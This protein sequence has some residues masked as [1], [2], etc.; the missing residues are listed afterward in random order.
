MPRTVGGHSI[1]PIRRARRSL[2]M[3]AAICLLPLTQTTADDE[4]LVLSPPAV[5]D[6]VKENFLA[7]RAGILPE[8]QVIELDPAIVDGIF[9]AHSSLWHAIEW[10]WYECEE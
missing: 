3:L 6:E 9:R 10:A 2:V 4:P 8:D 1:L 5:V 7:T